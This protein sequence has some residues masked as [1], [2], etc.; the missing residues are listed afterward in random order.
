M[1]VVSIAEVMIGVVVGSPTIVVDAANDEV[2]G[3]AKDVVTV[4]AEAASMA[5][6]LVRRTPLA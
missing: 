3:T 1:V 4:K 6:P 2:V 5:P